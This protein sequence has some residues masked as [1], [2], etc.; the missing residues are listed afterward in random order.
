MFK[1]GNAFPR[2]WNYIDRAAV[3]RGPYRLPT[4]L[5]QMWIR[6]EKNLPICHLFKQFENGHGRK[7]SVGCEPDNTAWL[8]RCGY[9]FVVKANV[10]FQTNTRH[11]FSWDDPTAD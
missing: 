7:L 5:N 9:Y 4:S 2:I 1:Q 3:S 10:H 8:V 11:R 6:L